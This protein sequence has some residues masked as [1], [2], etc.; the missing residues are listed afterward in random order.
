MVFSLDRDFKKSCSWLTRILIA[1]C[2]YRKH[3]PFRLSDVD[4][5]FRPSFVFESGAHLI[6]ALQSLHLQSF[7]HELCLPRLSKI[8]LFTLL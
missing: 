7:R 4:C 2:L 8:Y 3:W 6:E 5:L 1:H